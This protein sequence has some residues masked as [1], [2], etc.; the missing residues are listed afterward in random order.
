MFWNNSAHSNINLKCSARLSPSSRSRHRLCRRTA[1]ST[2]FWT[3]RKKL[4][5]TRKQRSRLLALELLDSVYHKILGHVQTLTRT[6]RSRNRS[7]GL[8]NLQRGWRFEQ[9]FDSWKTFLSPLV[10]TNSLYEKPTVRF[11]FFPLTRYSYATLNRFWEK[12]KKNDRFATWKL[13]AINSL[14]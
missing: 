4:H 11:S 10:R 7:P 14:I 6:I 8:S 1:T 9:I 2:H 5:C 3:S 13:H 12:K